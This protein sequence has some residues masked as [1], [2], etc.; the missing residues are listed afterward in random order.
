MELYDLKGKALRFLQHTCTV[1]NITTRV[2]SEF[3]PL[4]EEVDKM[5]MAYFRVNYDVLRYSVVFQSFL[6]EI[7]SG[8][9]VHEIIR[10]IEVSVVV[11]GHHASL[12]FC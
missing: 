5:Y 6:D 9:D 10:L 7:E 1:E 12:I 2:I 4:H 11:A 8:G 3:A